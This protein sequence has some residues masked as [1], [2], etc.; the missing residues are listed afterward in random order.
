VKRNLA[1]TWRQHRRLVGER[2]F[3]LATPARQPIRRSILR[4][5]VLESVTIV[6]EMRAVR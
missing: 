2:R 3:F 1:D 6:P 4:P 5:D